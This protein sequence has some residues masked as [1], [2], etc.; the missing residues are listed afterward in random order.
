MRGCQIIKKQD[1]SL[2]QIKKIKL[3]LSIKNQKWITAKRFQTYGKI[4]EPEFINYYSEYADEILVPRNTVE[5]LE[6]DVPFKLIVGK[7]YEAKIN[8][9]N[10]LRDYQLPFVKQIDFNLFDMIFNVPAGHGKT[11]LA[12]WYM[13]KVKQR[14]IIFVNTEYLKRQWQLRGSEF[15]KETIIDIDSKFLKNGSRIT[16]NIYIITLQLYNENKDYIKNHLNWD[17]GLEVFDECHRLGAETFYSVLENSAVPR[18]L[19]LTATY[20]RSD[21]LHLILKYNFGHTY[22]MENVLPKPKVYGYETGI[23][24]Q[25]IVEKNKL[26]DLNSLIEYLDTEK[27]MYRESSK[28][29]S[30]KTLD[31]DYSKINNSDTKYIEKCASTQAITNL[32]NI[33]C[34]IKRRVMQATNLIS[35][36][37]EN[38]R[39]VLFLSKRKELLKILFKEFK[40]QTDC[41]LL[42]SETGKSIDM[43]KINSK[44]LIFG[45]NQLAQEALDVPMLDTL[46]FFHAIKD[47]EQPIGRIARVAEGKNIPLVFYMVDKNTVSNGMLEAAK[48]YIPI[49]GEYKGKISYKQTKE[50]LSLWDAKKYSSKKI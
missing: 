45:I 46:I 43:T 5:Q 16:E 6:L 38:G 44:K 15:C 24:I 27:I 14:T 42:I 49:N 18:R 10:T 36:C 28:Y 2:E 26:L 47:T 48:K 40:K 41:V 4:Y 29:L 17:F 37:L 32:E 9:Y 35:D 50:I 19:A 34:D 39:R 22:V 30:F 13:A 31:F 12:L 8:F 23:L 11:V 3:A 20:R 33:Q 1:L 7:D 21:N 25:T